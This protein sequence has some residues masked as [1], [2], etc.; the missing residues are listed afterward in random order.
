MH[1]TLLVPAS[2]WTSDA[3]ARLALPSRAS[4]ARSYSVATAVAAATASQEDEND[5]DI[6]ESL[7][8]VDRDDEAYQ[9]AVVNLKNQTAGK[10]HRTL[11][12]AAQM[13]GAG[14]TE[15]GKNAVARAALQRHRLKAFPADVVEAYLG[16]VTVSFR[17]DEYQPED[18]QTFAK[19][20]ASVLRD[21]ITE[22]ARENPSEEWAQKA[23]AI[24]WSKVPLKAKAV[25]SA[26]QASTGRGL[27]L[28]FDEVR[29]DKLS[30]G[31]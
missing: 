10:A 11:V 26:F 25:V 18:G 5:F 22:T 30:P 29:D 24:H 9:V 17:L 8:F 4:S 27:F 1:G 23:L 3:R 15:L 31:R 7:Y 14:K 2:L 12:V 13:F 19:Y 16:A 6:T 28:H 21:A 20:I